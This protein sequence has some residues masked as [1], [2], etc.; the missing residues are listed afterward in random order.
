MC[1]YTKN[2]AKVGVISAILIVI[3]LFLPKSYVDSVYVSGTVTLVTVISSALTGYG[4]ARFEFKGKGLI[5]ILMLL[6]Y[7]LPK[8]LLFIPRLQMYSQLGIKGSMFALWGPALLGQGIQATFFILIFFQFFKMIP[9]QIEESAYLD[10]ANS[11]QIFI[12]IAVPMAIPAFVISATYGFAVNWNELFLT[13]LY[14]DGN[15]KTIPMLLQGL[16]AVWDSVADY[17]V[18]SDNVDITFTEAKS[19]AGTII[20]IIPMVIMYGIVQR[21]FIESIDNSGIAGE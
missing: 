17:A 1:L 7:I 11:F 12:K 6:I 10:G 21:Y 14:L 5:F 3:F 19:F 9:N 15:I 8:T 18:G 13:N 20:S 4:L 16:Q 2:F